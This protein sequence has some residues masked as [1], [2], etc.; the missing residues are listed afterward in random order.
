MRPPTL[1]ASEVS[2]KASSK[3][4]SKASGK[5]SRDSEMSKVSGKVSLDSKMSTLIGTASPLMTLGDALVVG[6]FVRRPSERNK[7]PYVSDVR[8][9]DGRIALVHT[10]SLDMGG[11]LVPGSR[12]LLRTATDK[13]G[14]PV[15]A[16]QVGKYGTPKC[17]FIMSLLRCNEVE[18]ESEGGV[19]IGA[20]PALGE[21]LADTLIRQGAL[22]AELGGSPV[23]TV[24]REVTNVG[25]TDMVRT[26]AARA[27]GCVRLPAQLRALT[28]GTN[29]GH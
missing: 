11:K 19:W 5:T 2:H 14:R 9:A 25:G 3:A 18:N 29:S 26:F 23:E 17:E 10:P 24:R 8:I 20:H 16:D 22:T 6:E 13:A 4:S 7:S 27:L 21:K 28:A 15:G 1:A 12:V